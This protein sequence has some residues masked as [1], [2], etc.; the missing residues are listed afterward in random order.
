MIAVGIIF[1]QHYNL[2]ALVF[3]ALA[4]IEKPDDDAPG[5]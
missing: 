1:T 2:I 5:L 3:I 4:S